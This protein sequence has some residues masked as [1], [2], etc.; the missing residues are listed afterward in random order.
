MNPLRAR[1]TQLRRV[2][3]SPNLELVIL[4][5]TANL[6]YNTY[7]RPSSLCGEQR[8]SPQLGVF[9]RVG[10]GYIHPRGVR[11]SRSYLLSHLY[12]ETQCE[13]ES[14]SR[15]SCQ[16]AAPSVFPRSELKPLARSKYRRRPRGAPRSWQQ[17]FGGA[18][19]YRAHFDSLS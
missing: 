3:R 7:A 11:F 4:R 13:V 14:G 10:T 8:P 15:G 17:F 19:L 16:N 6:N 2:A 5:G 18:L 9:G 1:A 12:E